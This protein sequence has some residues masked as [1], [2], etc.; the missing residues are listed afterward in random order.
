MIITSGYSCRL[1]GLAFD[2]AAEKCG[3][4]HDFLFGSDLS[5]REIRESDFTLPL[6]LRKFRTLFLTSTPQTG[7]AEPDK[8]P[9]ALQDKSF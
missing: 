3:L 8:S 1:S 9:P 5:D 7:E 6:I 2:Q 4:P